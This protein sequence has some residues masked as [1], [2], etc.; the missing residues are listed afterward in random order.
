[1]DNRRKSTYILT[2]ILSLI[3]ITI[4]GC[5]KTVS[6]ATSV[7]KE[8]TSAT[9]E[10]KEKN[11]ALAEKIDKMETLKDLTTLF[12]EEKEGYA[13]NNNTDV[14]DENG[15]K[16]KTIDL[17]SVL[18]LIGLTADGEYYET[19]DGYF[20]KSEDVSE[21]PLT[22]VVACNEILYTKYNN[23]K[24]HSSYDKTSDVIYTLPVNQAVLK[25][26]EVT[27]GGSTL[28]STGD[29]GWSEV[30]FKVNDEVIV[31]YVYTDYLAATADNAS[32]E[33]IEAPVYT[34]EEKA[35][36]VSSAESCGIEASATTDEEYFLLE[37]KVTS[38]KNE[39][40][41]NEWI[42][43]YAQSVADKYASSSS[44]MSGVSP[45]YQAVDPAVKEKLEREE[46]ENNRKAAEERAADP[47]PIVSE[48]DEYAYSDEYGDC[49]KHT[50][51]YKDGTMETWYWYHN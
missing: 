11:E 34:D 38:Y 43:Q 50:V 40:A 21:N 5:G 36:I 48:F 29:H 15:K 20:V 18:K 17:N 39:Q 47:N 22:G 25:S 24:V 37:E 46:E 31:G 7:V 6:S 14:Y 2:L 35:E 9:E 42:E 32:T 45:N 4:T 19:D 13:N 49:Y 30:K 23:V 3:I 41:T 27:F 51:N 28:D 10:L 8:I 1:M 33:A 12:N 44:S 16:V 26:G